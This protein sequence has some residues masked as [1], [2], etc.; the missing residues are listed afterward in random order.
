MQILTNHPVID[1]LFQEW[2]PRLGRDYTA[3]RHHVYRVF[4]LASALAGADGE[5]LEK[6]AAAAA[7][8]DASIWLDDTFDYLEPSIGRAEAHL[9]ENGH[10]SW[11]L[12]VKAMIGQHHKVSPWNGPGS[13]LVEAF[14]RADWLDVC[15]FALPTRL[16]RSFL[17]QVLK[18]FPRKGFHG[19]LVV[20]TI[21]WT[22]QHP[23]RP[24]PMFKL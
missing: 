12:E 6:L 22:R 18:R 24:L 4:N 23:F 8:H 7:F 13:R 16:P 17:G 3:Y 11:A 14:R 2:K 1:S 15:L 9:I 10:E 21:R 5:D 20:F 19:R